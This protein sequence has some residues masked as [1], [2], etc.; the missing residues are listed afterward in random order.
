MIIPNP[1]PPGKPNKLG[2]TT[3]DDSMCTHHFFFMS[4][5]TGTGTLFLL[6]GTG[7]AGYSAEFRIGFTVT[8]I[9]IQLFTSI[10]IRI[11][12]LIKVMRILRPLAYRPSRPPF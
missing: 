6:N 2:Y 7:T 3:Q 8:R 12:L 5:N 9:R 11:L 4:D 10:R 1:D